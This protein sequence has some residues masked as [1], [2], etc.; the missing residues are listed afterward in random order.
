MLNPRN[1]WENKEEYD[2]TAK[3]LADMGM[4][5]ASIQASLKGAHSTNPQTGQG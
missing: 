2:Q 4:A 3:Q 5:I 1:L